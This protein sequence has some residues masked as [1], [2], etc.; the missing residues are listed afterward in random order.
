MLC[1]I[2]GRHT[3]QQLLDY[4]KLYAQFFF[5]VQIY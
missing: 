3:N 1:P 4:G 5:A 2:L